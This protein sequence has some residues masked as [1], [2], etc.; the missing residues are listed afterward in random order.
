M[1]YIKIILHLKLDFRHYSETLFFSQS[2]PHLISSPFGNYPLS[3]KRLA[4]FS[5]S[6]EFGKTVPCP[7]IKDQPNN[8]HVTQSGPI[9]G[10][11]W[12][13]IY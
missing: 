4:L 10:F 7:L 11:L 12:D 2:V 1:I 8:R 9:K 5:H 6:S 13:F 3:F